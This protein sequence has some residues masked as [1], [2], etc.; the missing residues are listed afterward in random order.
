VYVFF[1]GLKPTLLPKNNGKGKSAGI[2]LIAM[3]PP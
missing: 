1:V 2:P 3:R